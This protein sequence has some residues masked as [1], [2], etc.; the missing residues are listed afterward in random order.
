MILDNLIAQG[1]AKPML[2]VMPLGYGAP[3]ILTYGFGA[4]RHEALVQRNLERFQKI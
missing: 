3:E 2:V 4:F 1:V